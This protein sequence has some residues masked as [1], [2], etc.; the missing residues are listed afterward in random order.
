MV[1]SLTHAR[2]RE[3]L[4]YDPETGRFTWRVNGC[5]RFMRAGAS[6]GSIKKRGHRQICIDQVIY[7]AGPLAV[8]WMTHRW[9]KRL[10]DHSNAIADDDR[11]TNIREADHSQNG[12]NSR[13]W[14]NK[15]YSQF[16]GVTF[17]KSH[18]RFQATIKINYRSI[19]LGR[20]DTAE[21]AHAAYIKAARQYFGEFAREG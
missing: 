6:A 19:Y 17:D 12:A 7:M 21:E 15:K 14:K 2:L 3:L 8:F 4:D 1:A 10:V 16:K 13:T 9:P 11:W 20:F 18:S 5:G